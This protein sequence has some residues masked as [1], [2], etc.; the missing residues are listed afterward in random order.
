MEQFLRIGVITQPHGIRGEVKVFPTTDSP[1]RFQE[2]KHVMIRHEKG[3][4]ETEIT[5]V[6]FFK[7]LAIVH[8]ACFDVPEEAAKYKGADIMIRRKDAQ[9]LEEGE[10]YIADLIGCRVFLD[11]ESVSV[12][13]EAD[14]SISIGQDRCIGT[15]KD[16]LQTGANDVYVVDTG[17]RELL[18]PVIKDCIKNVDIER[19]EILVHLL[20]GLI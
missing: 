9:P 5:G 13:Q 15:V 11:E 4:I 7:N 14:G 3:E 19:S 18:I 16:V 17:A 8:F 6:K 12:L 20:S 2:V 1:K 10:Y